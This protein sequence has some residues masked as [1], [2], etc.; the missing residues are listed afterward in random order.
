MSSAG[1]EALT[2]ALLDKEPGVTRADL[3][4]APFQKQFGVDAF[5][6]TATG[7]IV[8]SCKCYRTVKKD[9]LQGWSDDFLKHLDSHWRPLK[10]C[11]FILAV[12]AP[13]HSTQRLADIEAQRHRFKSVGL[14]Y[15][16]WAPRQ[17]QELLREQ[18]GIVSQHLGPEWEP[19]LCGRVGGAMQP[20]GQIAVTA[21]GD[22]QAQIGALKQAFSGTVEEQIDAAA[23]E[24]ENGGAAEIET[25]ISRIR[26]APSW[27]HLS[28]RAQARTLRL[29]A[30]LLINRGNLSGAEALSEQADSIQP[31]E[32]P[33]LR[34][35][36]AMNRQGPLKALEALG[37][38][39]TDHGWALRIGLLL[40]AGDLDQ[41][42]AALASMPL[43]DP[44]GL[45][46][47]A[48]L[49]L[50]L[51]DAPGALASAS[52]AEVQMPR[53]APVR[54]AGAMARYA[55]ALSASAPPDAMYFPQPVPRNLVRQDDVS[56]A[57]LRSA[58]EVFHQLGQALG[59]GLG[60]VDRVWALACLCNSVGRTV[61]ASTL[62]REILED[63]PY[64]PLAI[65]WALARGLDIDRER[66]LMAVR[67]EIESGAADLN[68]LRAFEWLAQESVPA[69]AEAWLR[70]LPSDQLSADF[71]S[72]MTAVANRIEA[73]RAGIEHAEPTVATLEEA[74][75][76]GDWSPVEAELDELAAQDPAPPII[77]AIADELAGA[78]RW[79]ALQPHIG[80]IA[81]FATAD[82]IRVAA[83]V[84][85]NA[86]AAQRAVD[87]L[88][89]HV[90]AFP[91]GRLPFDL[92]R[93]EARALVHAGDLPEA[94]R[95]AAALAGE[96][97]SI[98][99]QILQA[100][101]RFAIGDLAGAAPALRAAL[102]EGAM[103]APDALRW[104]G[105]FVGED[106]DLARLLW[107]A[108][109]ASDLSDE[110][111]LGAVDL[112]FR[113]NLARERPDLVAAVQRLASDRPELVQ[114]PS[115][116]EVVS[117]M[118]QRMEFAGEVEGAWTR[119][120]LPVHLVFSSLRANLA[121]LYF[122]E[123]PPRSR[124][125]PI[126]IRHGG[127]GD[128]FE[129]P[130]PFQSWRL[131]L[132]ITG[133]L[134]AEQLGVL[135][136]ADELAI[137]IRVSPSMPAALMTL[138]ERSRPN[139]PERAAAARAFAAALAAGRV[140]V[141]SGPAGAVALVHDAAAEGHGV[142]LGAIP[143][144]LRRI[145]GVDPGVLE[146]AQTIL[147]GADEAELDAGTALICQL[148][149]LN[150]VAEAGVLDAVLESFDVWIEV[151][152]AQHL[153]AEVGAADRGEVL[154]N[155]LA[156]VRRLVRD[157]IESGRYGVLPSALA[158]GEDQAI[159]SATI[160]DPIVQTLLDAIRG[161]D[162]PGEIL[163]VDDRHL[164]GYPRAGEA[165]VVGAFDVLDRLKQDGLLSDQN[166]Y[167]ALRRLR[168]GGALFLPVTVA[169]VLHHL[170]AAAIIA[171]EVVET[172]G[173]AA[174]RRDV[175]LALIHEDGLK[176]VERPG[177]LAGRPNEF[178]FILGLRRLAESAILDVWSDD[179]SID[180]A[181]ARSDWLWSALRAEHLRRNDGAAFDP[182]LFPGLNIGG[183]AASAIHISPGGSEPPMQV[184][185]AFAAWLEKTIGSRLKAD[186]G[187]ADEA[188]RMT[189]MLIQSSA[190]PTGDEPRD[191]RY[192]AGMQRLLRLA[193]ALLPDSLRDRVAGDPVVRRAVRLTTPLA[194]QVRGVA[195]E[196]TGFWRAV[197]TAVCYGES[198]VRDTSGKRIRLTRVAEDAVRLS[199]A[200]RTTLTDPALGVLGIDPRR[201]QFAVEALL[202]EVDIPT[203]KR[204][205]NRARMANASTPAERMRIVEELRTASVM[206]F[207]RRLTEGL[208]RNGSISLA[209]FE[210]PPAAAWLDLLRWPS[211]PSGDPIAE[212]ARGLTED[213]GGWTA[214][215][216]LAAL[217]VRLPDSVYSAAAAARE[218]AQFPA[219]YA[220]TPM[221]SFHRLHL[222][223]RKPGVSNEEL[224]GAV[225]ALLADYRSPASI[226]TVL[227]HWGE[228]RF[229]QQ[230]GWI[231]VAPLA[232][233]AIVWTYADCVA[234]I[235]CNMALD[236]QA[237]AE[238]LRGRL[239]PRRLTQIL[240][241]FHGSDDSA[242]DPKAVQPEPLLMAGLEF[243]LGERFDGL[244]PTE[245]R[246]EQFTAY[247]GAQL[248]DGRIVCRPMRAM[249]E[250]VSPYPTWLSRP[251][252]DHGPFGSTMLG[253]TFLFDA[254]KALAK[255]PTDLNSWLYLVAWGPPSVSEDATETLRGVVANFDVGNF[256]EKRGAPA[257]RAVAEVASRLAG[258]DAC[259]ALLEKL[260]AFADWQSQKDRATG[261]PNSAWLPSIIEAAATA[262]R[263]YEPGR[264]MERFGRF[265]INLMSLAPTTAS[266]L[267][268]VFDAAV[269]QTSTSGSLELWR[270]LLVA[271]AS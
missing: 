251:P 209:F 223:T 62:C 31:Q 262:A 147:G 109:T 6:E 192:A 242:F 129:V 71:A 227:L 85:Y 78:G 220:R 179:T 232:R 20:S 198:R 84:A 80:L 252:A 258:E 170:R 96:S 124:R 233:V 7:V 222:E 25:V 162:T 88:G 13:M 165:I 8:A 214:F 100:E 97:G 160:D 161:A 240:T 56:Q 169:E 87:L 271:R 249:Q 231:D 163:W 33:R 117:M 228:R 188:A 27:P 255:D 183:L 75:R 69:E 148:G 259:S 146:S 63:V 131:S 133:L 177:P 36:I 246:S 65:G 106:P 45:R 130:L 22:L 186:S 70:Q 157:R 247:F 158:Q 11:K 217:P 248:E 128:H 55:M 190:R 40:N 174:I 134:L 82:S 250:I 194:I 4:G 260:L 142:G 269:D 241:L 111:A 149:V 92:R 140:K 167:S 37:A 9:Q 19:R 229:S 16:V 39:T 191:P 38:P 224:G 3:Y 141:G 18:P 156:R 90:Q 24:L 216:R 182:R 212:A 132:D 215:D 52:A 267:R 173:L 43:E 207:G 104:S 66:S 17:L 50:M 57:R 95:R 5:G 1:F 211:D 122:L 12:A 155:W 48:Y 125:R 243:A 61:E 151:A 235:L 73:R 205:A 175:A 230:A 89:Q 195:I 261:Q 51:G 143:A 201:Q 254:A 181:R 10:V 118:R 237:T 263:S 199:G 101:V 219:G 29:E 114:T 159:A 154:A 197:R 193:I 150:Q 265:A 58:Y 99:D 196:V 59:Q 218:L 72:E 203:S 180:V 270:A 115:L 35:L 234:D 116:E 139:Q 266:T 172:P 41:A 171:G 144:A 126:L 49:Q 210:P 2:C 94:L 44:E 187:L 204:P 257:L 34:A 184:R 213:L 152:T 178:P 68:V 226:F 238:A 28:A 42:E 221:F 264:G 202:D 113:L 21:V 91:G 105:R 74:H 98:S 112:A 176:L 135:A 119:G 102:H 185:R 123:Q 239:P 138:E 60:D 103:P 64:S 206:T 54:R 77:L 253:E 23:L 53:R 120:E 30:S 76:T 189:A 236:L 121:D 67:A 83:F 208:S 268:R 136:L 26:T 225:D 81:S 79:T 32:E 15:D 137:P 153:L 127:R 168:G 86:G 145:G 166:Y 244:E 93:L 46:L 200:V 164:S 245:V 14:E 108:A 256:F 107:R 110:L 47:R